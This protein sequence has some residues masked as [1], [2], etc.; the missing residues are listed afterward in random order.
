MKNGLL[1]VAIC[2]SGG[3]TT[4]REII[5]A[6]KNGRLLHVNP[7]L[8]ISSR[9]EAGG[10]KKA[11]QEGIA[12]R[13]IVVLSRKKF[14]ESADFGEAI[15][16][17]CRL[18]SVDLIA[19]C[20][21]IPLMPSNVIEEYQSMIFNQHPGPIDQAR[22]GFGG[23]G[24][25]GLRVHHA[26]LYFANRIGRPLR[27]EAIVHRV[28]NEIDGGAIIGIRPVEIMET[29]DANAL[30]TRVLPHEHSLVIETILKFSEFGGPQ[31]IYRDHPLINENEINLLQKAKEEGIKAFPNG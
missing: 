20:G 5:I 25:Y 22:P 28:T 8:I 17:E 29:D 10:I 12:G 2:I 9:E 21:F 14:P 24:M 15:I 7:A 6:S 23:K 11:E 13:N 1:N 18:R 19:Q 3:G 31:E 16:Q 27:T 26:V 30:A 4:M